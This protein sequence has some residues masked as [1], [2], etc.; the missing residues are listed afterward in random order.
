[1][2]LPPVLARHEHVLVICPFQLI[3]PLKGRGDEKKRIL[4]K[5]DSSQLANQKKNWGRCL[6]LIYIADHCSN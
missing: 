4:L 3:A 5:T 6:F 1:M 2:T